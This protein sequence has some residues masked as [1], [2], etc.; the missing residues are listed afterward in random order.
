MSEIRFYHL[1]NQKIEQA[2]PGLIKKALDGN[3]KILVHMEQ[4]AQLKS[5]D[6]HLWT[7]HPDS[8][9]PHGSGKDAY[10][11]CQ[12]IWLDTK[13]EGPNTPNLMIELADLD[14][15]GIS[16]YDLICLM[17]EDWDANRKSAARSAWKSLKETGEHT[18]SY[19]QQTD[20]G[21]WEKKQ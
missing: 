5:L 15:D 12:P 19:W 13:R 6:T 3:F 9:L 17:F 11:E 4:E 16:G 2:L 21:G 7:Y 20:T 18:L 10:P 8:F 1:Q 14:I